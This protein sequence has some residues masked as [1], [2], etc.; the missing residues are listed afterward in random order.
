MKQL[1]PRPK[2]IKAEQSIAADPYPLTVEQRQHQQAALHLKA[3][4]NELT[5]VLQ[6]ELSRLLHDV[7][8]TL[9]LQLCQ[10]TTL[11]SW[12]AEPGRFL[13]A[14][15]L[16]V[17]QQDCGYLAMDYVSLHHLVDLSLGG[18]LTRQPD[19]ADK[20]E[21]SR[22]ELRVTSRLLQKQLQAIQTLLFG[23]QAAF[24]AQLLPLSQCPQGVRY[25]A[26]KVRLLLSHEAL[27]WYLWLPVSFFMPTGSAIPAAESAQPAVDLSRW[28]QIP[29]KGQ[30]QMAR[31]K[32]N[33][34]QLQH[35][36]RT[37]AILPLELPAEMPLNLNNKS[38]YLG[39][40]AEEGTALVFQ[41]TAA[42]TRDN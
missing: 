14:S 3:R 39:R 18:E 4:L 6:I 28:S 13:L 42:V 25:Q 10:G 23:E 12:L 37:G 30:V 19:V 16:S 38:L 2:L 5:Q 31:C 35:C 11:H 21:L 24:P 32:V 17:P 26:L 34:S 7:D 9:D 15:A 36:L 33:L 29:V 1:R 8:F 40:V 22:S 20:V 41:I 27:S